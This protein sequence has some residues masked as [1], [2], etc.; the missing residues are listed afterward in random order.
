LNAIVRLTSTSYL[1][2]LQYSVPNTFSAAISGGFLG[3]AVLGMIAGGL[4]A[5][6]FGRKHTYVASLLVLLVGCVG[7][8]T[9]SG[10]TV[11]EQLAAWR[12]IV[13]IGIG[14]EVCS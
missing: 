1:F 13:G 14:A 4:A 5:D 3:G 6:V 11:V 7:S 8:V 10:S 9:A 2:K 12:A